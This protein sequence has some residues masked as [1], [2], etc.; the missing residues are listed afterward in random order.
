[1]N[2]N[3]ERYVSYFI[4][5]VFILTIMHASSVLL[6]IGLLTYLLMIMLEKLQQRSA[7]IESILFLT[8]FSIWINFLL[9]KKAFLTHGA[10]VIW[11]NIPADLISIYFAQTNIID[12]VVKMGLIP[13]ILGGY[14]FY[15]YIFR[16]KK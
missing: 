13:I 6:I 15:R 4:I 7:E 8:F 9:Y 3:K 10:S 2:I 11:R 12:G 5:S 14:I 16:E 1:M